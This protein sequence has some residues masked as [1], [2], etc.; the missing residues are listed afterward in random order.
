MK[1]FKVKTKK[2]FEVIFNFPTSINEVSEEYLNKITKPLHIADNYSLIALAYSE[3]LS[4]LIMT[5]RAGKRDTKIK[6]TPIFIKAGNTDIEFIKNA[7]MKQRVVSMPTQ[8]SLGTHVS[9]PY[10][11]LTIEYFANVVKDAEYKDIYEQEVSNEDQRECTFLEFKIIPNNDIMGLL[12]MN[13]E[14]IDTEY[15]QINNVGE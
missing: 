15:L 7:K 13:T 1:Q 11:N 9:I 2:G 6:V 3:K 4:T 14:K 8:I 12:D 5:A 10:H